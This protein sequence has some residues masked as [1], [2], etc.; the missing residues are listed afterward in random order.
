L[1]T[2]QRLVESA[3]HLKVL[4]NQSI[5]DIKIIG[6]KMTVAVG[7]SKVLLPPNFQK[8]LEWGFFDNSLRLFQTDNNK[9]LSV[10]EGTHTGQIT[11]VATVDQEMF[12]TGGSMVNISTSFGFF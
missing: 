9:C 12:I 4:E 10:F 5:S 6:D 1:Y 8:Y 7:N 2:P 11:C 3:A